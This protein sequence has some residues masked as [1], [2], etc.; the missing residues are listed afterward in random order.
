MKNQAYEIT[1][2]GRLDLLQIWNY[3]AEADSL[4]AADQVLEDIEKAIERIV[5][6]PGI[7]HSR[8][9]LTRRDLLFYT[10]GSY[11][12]AYR[13]KH[14]PLYVIRVLHGSRNIKRLLREW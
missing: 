8:K 6:F 12:I 10:I 1:A 14:T 5:E 7:G 9:D 4:D 3:L 2:L 11:M 13:P